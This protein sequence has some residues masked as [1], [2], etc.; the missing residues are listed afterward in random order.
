MPSKTWYVDGTFKLCRPPFTQLFSVNAFVKSGDLAK[1]VPL[2][3]VL[4]SGKKKRDYR[5]VLRKVLALLPS[6][7]TVTK[8]V[9]DFESALWTVFCQ[10]MP[11]VSLKGC[12]FHWTQA[13][14][15]KVRA[16]C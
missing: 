13:L 16:L 1:Q 4:M 11:D 8:T 9:L 15:K 10:V 12:L 7:P 14:W 5:E 6:S 3:F 2:L